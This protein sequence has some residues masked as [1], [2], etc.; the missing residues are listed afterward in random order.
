MIRGVP[1][2]FVAL[3]S[4]VALTTVLV[5][6]C[7]DDTQDTAEGNQ[8]DTDH[9]WKGQ[10]RALEKAKNVEDTLRDAAKRQS[11]ASQ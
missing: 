6:G 7:S 10:V 2:P 11:G 4:A 3:A 5:A 9:V 1:N 8:Q